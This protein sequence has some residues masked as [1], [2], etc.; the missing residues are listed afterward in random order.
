MTTSSGVLD[1]SPFEVFSEPFPYA[2]SSQA[3]SGK[4]SVDILNWLEAEAPWRLV[5][6]E[7]YEQFEFSFFDTMLPAQLT[8]LQGKVFLNA[9]KGQVQKLFGVSLGNRIDATAHKLVSGQRIRV[10][11]DFIPDAE[12]HRLLIQ[13]NR[14]WRDEDGGFLLFFNSPNP[15]DI[16]KVFRP[17]HNSAVA[18]AISPDS[19]HAV[20][21]IHGS[22]RF[23]LVYSFYAER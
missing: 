23:T 9:L 18:F 6:T 14:G 21:A 8:F 5:E 3:F 11:N 13:L 19:N 12:T 10:H 16:H 1:F 2:F 22:E 7:F 17:V 15:A 4:R 20:T